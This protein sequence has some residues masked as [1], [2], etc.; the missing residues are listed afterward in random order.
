MRRMLQRGVKRGREGRKGGGTKNIPGAR[1]EERRKGRE[2]ISDLPYPRK[3]GGREGSSAFFFPL[4]FLL[5]SPS[6]W[7]TR[8]AQAEKGRRRER[9]FFRPTCRRRRRLPVTRLAALRSI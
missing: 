1:E 2:G 8:E 3:K 7:L 5:L 6:S 9:P 4:L